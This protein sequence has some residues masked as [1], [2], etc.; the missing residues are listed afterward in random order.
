[1]LSIEV[2]EGLGGAIQNGLV[3][4]GREWQGTESDQAKVSLSGAVPSVLLDL[5]KA[6]KVV[7]ESAVVD[8]ECTPAEIVQAGT[9][10]HALHGMA[11]G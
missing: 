9:C 6:I 1:M 7:L 10:K 8:V 2:A 5:R 11:L 4:V 3:E